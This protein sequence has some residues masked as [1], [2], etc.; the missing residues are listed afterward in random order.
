MT[1]K[2][3][4]SGSLANIWVIPAPT[5]ISQLIAGLQTDGVFT[6][7]DRLW[8]FAQATQ[9]LALSDL[10]AGAV[11][12]NVNSTTFT[13]NV[14]FTGDGA[15]MYI[16]TNWNPTVD[17]VNY[18]Q[19]SASLFAWSNTGGSIDKTIVGWQNGHESIIPGG[20][21]SNFFYALNSNNTNDAVGGI[22]GAGLYAVSRHDATTIEAYKNG[23]S[24]QTNAAQPSAAPNNH[25]FN[26]LQASLG[27]DTRQCCAAGWGG[28]L[29]GTD[30]S[31]LYT[32]LRTYMTAVGVP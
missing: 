18:A 7:L 22:T 26:V 5:L 16:E 3:T 27:F 6:K 9:A 10:I 24:V 21:G 2:W 13:A 23:A 4:T 29:T 31:N 12:T 17:A 25:N 19:N 32:R 14:G 30:Q 15:A 11:A 20:F 8:V 28:D 1:R